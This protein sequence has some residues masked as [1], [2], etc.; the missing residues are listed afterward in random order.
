MRSSFNWFVVYI[1]NKQIIYNYFL[2]LSRKSDF[3]VSILNL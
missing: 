3:F 1:T 2:F